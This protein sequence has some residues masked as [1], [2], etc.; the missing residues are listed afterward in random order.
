MSL[1]IEIKID[2][3]NLTIFSLLLL[4]KNNSDHSFDPDK[5]FPIERISDNNSKL[6]FNI[7]IV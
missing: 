3:K 4:D 7:S 1:L 6:L 5:I 2:N